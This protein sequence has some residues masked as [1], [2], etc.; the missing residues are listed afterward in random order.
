MRISGAGYDKFYEAAFN[1]EVEVQRRKR[2]TRS[3]TVQFVVVI[4][5]VPTAILLIALS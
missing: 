1:E 3:V 5:I 4:I 2:A